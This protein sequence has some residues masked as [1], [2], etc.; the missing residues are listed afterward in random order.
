M[1]I[2]LQKVRPVRGSSLDCTPYLDDSAQQVIT[3]ELERTAFQRTHP[4]LRFTLSNLSDTFTTY[5]ADLARTD[6]SELSVYDDNERRRFWGHV[7]PESVTF[8]LRDKWVEFDAFASNKRFWDLAKRTALYQP[9]VLGLGMAFGTTITLSQL[10][11]YQAAN[12]PIRDGDTTFSSIDLGIYAGEYVRGYRDSLDYGN[13]GRFQ[14]LKP[15]TTWAEYLEALALFFNAEF[16]IDPQTYEFKMVHRGAV[17]NDRRLNIDPILMDSDEI[18]V[19]MLDAKTCDYLYSYASVEMDGPVVTG[20]SHVESSQAL[21]GYVGLLPGTHAWMVT[22]VIDGGECLVTKRTEYTLEANGKLY[23]V[24]LRIPAG[25]TGTSARRI[26]RKDPIN[27]YG[28]FQYLKEIA[29]NAA[30]DFTD[31]AGWSWIQSQRGL[32]AIENLAGAWYAFNE[33]TNAWA[34]PILDIP[35]GEN[36]PEGVVLEIAPKL[37]FTEPGYK[38]VVRDYSLYDIYQHFLKNFDIDEPATRARWVDVFRT[39]RIV[40]AKVVGT[41]FGIGDSFVSNKELFPNDFTTDNRM[42]LRKAEINLLNGTSTLSL[43]TI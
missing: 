35:E 14:D 39:R 26:Y 28:A 8:R 40:R 16:Y 9:P 27:I 23:A 17:L 37:V 13:A 20:T 12:T 30:V 21:G 1:R 33:L 3:Q 34:S 19:Q 29:G 41:S 43:M 18:D 4:D 7:D 11:N 6:L 5:F 31:N 36:T 10:L 38:T 25:P 15:G 2:T 32:P 24:T 22:F 42:I